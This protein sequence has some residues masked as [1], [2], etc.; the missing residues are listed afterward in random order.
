MVEG[1]PPVLDEGINFNNI[2]P[3]LQ[4]CFDFAD[5]SIGSKRRVLHR[6]NAGQDIAI[7]IVW[8]MLLKT[9]WTKPPPPLKHHLQR[10]SA[11]SNCRNLFG[12]STDPLPSLKKK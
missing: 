2:G 3:P 5:H 7:C 9:I 12:G 4:L 10:K 1:S 8:T 11:T 6:A